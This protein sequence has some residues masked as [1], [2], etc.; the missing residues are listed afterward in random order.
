VNGLLLD[1]MTSNEVTAKDS[2]EEI[3]RYLESLGR[4][5]NAAYLYPV[6]G[7][8]EL[9]QAFCRMCAVFGG[10]YMLGVDVES[11]TENNIRLSNGNSFSAEHIIT[12][13]ESTGTKHFMTAVVKLHQP[14]SQIAPQMFAFP[15]N[16][17]GNYHRIRVLLLGAGSQ[18]TPSEYC[19]LHAR[20]DSESESD[21]MLRLAIE[22]VA[23]HA[24]GVVEF[25]SVLEVPFAVD[26]SEA[27]KYNDDIHGICMDHIVAEAKR[28]FEAIVGPDV[29]WFD[30]TDTMMNQ[31]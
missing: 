30:P 17:F 19:S 4:F 9:S 24:E 13:V 18:T 1:D 5:G 7:I 11:M 21:E 27:Y 22:R 3:R 14:S 28:L 10:V 15:P 16:S 6:Y 25:S 20:K 29:D 12:P 8:S 26:S 31:E 23:Q 2:L